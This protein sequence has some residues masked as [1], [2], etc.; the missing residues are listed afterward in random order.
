MQRSSSPDCRGSGLIY[1][2]TTRCTEA[3]PGVDVRVPGFGQTYP[4]EYLDPSKRS[5][6]IYFF[7]IVQSLVNWGYT[8]NAD[9]RGAP[10]DWRKA[11]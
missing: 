8:R 4:L 11:P 2:W 5:V 7:T 6:G 3:P 9:V 1:N 10:Y